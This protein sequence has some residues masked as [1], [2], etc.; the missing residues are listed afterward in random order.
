[1]LRRTQALVGG[2][3]L[4]ALVSVG[5]WAAPARAQG[6]A[7]ELEVVAG[8]LNN[9]RG[10]A[11]AARGDDILVAEAGVGG[12]GP[13]FE[14]PEGTVCLGDTG[15]V[16][17]VD[18]DSGEV[19]RVVT[20]L[21]SLA[22]ASG[23]GA[24]GPHDVAPN[25]RR[26]LYIAVGLGGN[27]GTRAGL[28]AGG[29]LLGQLLLATEGGRFRAVAD[30]AAFEEAN[31]PDGSAD[32]ATGAPAPDSNP[33]GLVNRG[34][35]FY[36]ADAGGNTLLG[37]GGKGRTEVAA[38]FPERL[39]DAPPFLGLPPGAQIPMQSVPNSVAIGPDGAFYVGEL[40]GFPF[41]VGGANV[42]RVGK[43][44][45]PEVFASGFTNIIDIA[46]D[47]EGNLYVLEIAAAS[48]LAEGQGPPEGRLVRVDADGG[49]QTVLAQAGLVAP[50]SVLVGDDELYISNF[51]IFPGAGQ[52]VRLALEDE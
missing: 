11:F 46:F 19:R 9:P 25:G 50:G 3:A 47:D 45:A 52:I 32:P 23:F 14:G 36:V 38:V 24:T 37:V 22:D 20:G 49:G 18:P 7:G 21:P 42:Y 6:G 10:L 48:L 1:M 28:G 17:R 2:V 43:G 8:G 33:Y 27:L 34:G 4:A 12:P 44:G 5:G 51:S 39:V 13:C 41:P 30:L 16:A 40:T 35:R 26:N 29:A 31:N 15:A